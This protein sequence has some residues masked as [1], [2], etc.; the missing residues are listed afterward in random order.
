M[1]NA[2]LVS[3][4][5]LVDWSPQIF[6]KQTSFQLALLGT[7]VDILSGGVSGHRQ[8]APWAPWDSSPGSGGALAG[9]SFWSRSTPITG[10]PALSAATLIPFSNLFWGLFF[11]FC[12]RR[13][14][15]PTFFC[16]FCM[17]IHFLTHHLL[18]ESKAS[19]SIVEERTRHF[20]RWQRIRTLC[21]IKLQ[22]LL[23]PK[24]GSRHHPFVIMIMLLYIVDSNNICQDWD[25][26]HLLTGLLKL[27]HAAKIACNS[28]VLQIN[29]NGFAFTFPL[30]VLVMAMH[31]Q[32][33]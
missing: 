11:A 32:K 5:S 14:K 9:L 6:K 13:E 29:L 7:F 12:T 18:P 28:N 26:C 4:Q 16:V 23:K 33:E 31:S 17:K 27:S 21:L 3:L 24:W 15:K 22:P 30:L 8:G 2:L 19:E 20:T 10:A 1:Q 25:F